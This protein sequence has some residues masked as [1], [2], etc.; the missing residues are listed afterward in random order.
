[1]NSSH[2]IILFRQIAQGFRSADLRHHLAAL[3]GCDPES[4]SQGA[5]T[6]Q[7]RRLF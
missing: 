3:S 2:A 7:L 4:I 1:V 5:I 6:Y